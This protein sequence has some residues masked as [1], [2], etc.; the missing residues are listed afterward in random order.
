VFIPEYES[1][2]RNSDAIHIVV[3]IGTVGINAL[4]LVL[5]SKIEGF[6]TIQ[7][8]VSFNI[9]VSDKIKTDDLK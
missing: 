3:F 9:R 1:G 7:I 2:S 4:L 6:D 8:Q 5:R